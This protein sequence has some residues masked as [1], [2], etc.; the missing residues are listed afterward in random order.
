MAGGTRCDLTG[1]VALVTGAGGGA[2]GGLGAVIAREL[3]AAGARVAVHDTTADAA[4]ETAR[5]LREAG[6]E[7][8]AFAA[9]V[10]DSQQATQLVAEVIERFGKI[11]ILVNNAEYRTP[12]YRADQI[13]TEEWRRSVALNVH[14]PFYLSRA[15]VR[16]MRTRKYGRIINVSN[17][18][19]IRTSVL[20]GVPYV[21]TKEALYGFTRHLATEVAQHG[22]TVNA[23]LPG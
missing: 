1:L 16:D 22:I 23:I 10:A 18:A 2:A 12:A 15:A 19:A 8:A 4:E 5:V 11:D 3:A 17:I 14:A 7:A 21:T 13:P 9:D 6:F 20:H